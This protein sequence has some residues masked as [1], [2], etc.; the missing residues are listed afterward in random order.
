[1]NA[2]SE[3]ALARLD[4]GLFRVRF[5]RLTPKER[6]YVLAMA[7]LGRGPYRSADVAARLGEPVQALG[8]CRSSIIRKGMIYSPQHG[9]IEFTGP[10]FD[11]FLRRAFLSP[12]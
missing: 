8:P 1:M 6:S 3:R 2:A 7:Q 5:D 10:M 12:A 11:E 4:E 9:D